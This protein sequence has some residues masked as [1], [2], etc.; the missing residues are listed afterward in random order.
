MKHSVVVSNLIP[1]RQHSEEVLHW[2]DALSDEE[3]ARYRSGEMR[4]P[5]DIY[6]KLT[7]ILEAADKIR[8]RLSEESCMFSETFLG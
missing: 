3:Y 6:R 1:I 7:A 2:F 8:A 5:S 4:I